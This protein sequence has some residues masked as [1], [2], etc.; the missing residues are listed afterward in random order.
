MKLILL[1]LLHQFL[2]IFSVAAFSIG[3]PLPHTP[4]FANTHVLVTWSGVPATV[5]TLSIQLARGASENALTSLMTLAQGLDASQSSTMAFLPK[6]APSGS[7][8]YIVL[9]GDDTPPSRASVPIYI[10]FGSRST[11]IT[12]TTT[13]APAT[14]TTT[15]PPSPSQ[16]T[17]LTITSS[18][19]TTT[20]PGPTSLSQT[21]S[22]P[23]SPITPSFSS[24]LTPTSTAPA[25]A[26]EDGSSLGTAQ[27]A[28][29]AVGG[30]A[31]VGLILGAACLMRR[32]RREDKN[33]HRVSHDMFA[34]P[35]LHHYHRDSHQSQY[36]NAY[37][38]PTYYQRTPS[39]RVAPPAANYPMTALAPAMSMSGSKIEETYGRKAIYGAQPENYSYVE[40]KPHTQ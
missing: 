20:P 15:L 39:P 24:S 19:S 4:V 36:E 6:D 9:Q 18:F 1:L 7:G 26:G 5:K 37:P 29:I 22:S 14:S 30:A 21:K 11:A 35:A 38:S 25:S 31:A 27:V 28:G 17:T 33:E 13:T 2:F 12:T 23:S 34:D 8:S 10:M 32:R 3:L 40:E 16:N